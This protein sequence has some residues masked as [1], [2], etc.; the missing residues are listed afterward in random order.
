MGRPI[1]WDLELELA[2]WRGMEWVGSGDTLPP[3]CQNLL[4]SLCDLGAL[5]SR[6][7]PPE[8]WPRIPPTG[9]HP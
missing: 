8:R 5:G 9:L 1:L 4:V 2:V 6:K 7:G 3:G